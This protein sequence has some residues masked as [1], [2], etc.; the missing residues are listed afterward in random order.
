MPPTPNTQNNKPITQRKPKPK[1]TTRNKRDQQ[2]VERFDIEYQEYA[3]AHYIHYTNSRADA[4]P[5]QYSRSYCHRI[6]STKMPTCRSAQVETV[7]SR[8]R[9]R[10][11][12]RTGSEKECSTMCFWDLRRLVHE[13][14]E[15]QRRVQI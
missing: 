15:E 9:T 11:P 8:I 12:P 1:N 6:S 14:G 5:K 7:P 13:K 3:L 2:D 4:K 10:R